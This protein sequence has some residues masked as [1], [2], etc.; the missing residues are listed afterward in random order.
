MVLTQSN[1]DTP[2]TVTVEAWEDDLVEGTHT[3][4]INFDVFSVDS[5]YNNI[6]VAGVPN[7]TITGN[8]SATVSFNPASVSQSEASTP[9]AFT[10]TL[11]NPVASGVSLS[12][13]STN[14]TATAADFTVISGGTVNFSANSTTPQTVNLTVNNDA[15]DEDDESFALTLSNPMATGTVTI[16][17]ASATGTILDNDGLPTLSVANV[18]QLEGNASNLLTFRVNL[19]PVSGRSVS[20]TRA[21]AAGTAVSTFQN[22]DFVA[23]TAAPVTI[24][25]GQTGVDIQVT[26]NGDTV[27]EDDENFS[28]NL[29]AVDNATPGSLSATGTL[30]DD[31]Q[32]STTTTITADLP[33]PSVVGE[34]HP[35]TVE[36]RA[37]TLSPLGTVNISDGAGASCGPITLTA[38]TAPTSTASCNLTGTSAGNRNLTAMYTPAS[39]AF[40]ASSG[41]AAHTVNAAATTLSL[42]GPSRVRINQ[43]ASFSFAL[44]VI[45]PGAGTP[46]GKVTLSSRAASCSATLPATRCNLTFTTLGSRTLTASYASDGNFSS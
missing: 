7:V 14:G 26:I 10:V 45:A 15:L 40:T 46:T 39:A 27:F 21:T 18:S 31:D 35:V 4:S 30:E 13:N 23:L 38:G 16:E 20:F 33:D 25:P 11:S 2:K 12:V 29:T 9:M 32:Q 8:D 42:S 3:S 43:P 34:P 36:V 37:Q 1:W 44:A 19:N 24:M 41:A 22:A 6:S 17:T 5:G 28:L